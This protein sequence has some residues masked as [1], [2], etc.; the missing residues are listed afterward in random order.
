MVLIK[1]L[2]LSLSLFAKTELKELTAK[3]NIQN[4]RYLTSKND[5]TFYVK[6][7]KSLSVSSNLK[8][9]EIISNDEISDYSIIKHPQSDLYLIT[10]FKN[11]FSNLTANPIGQIYLF[12]IQT[13]SL[14]PFTKG[15]APSFSQNGEYFYYYNP[16]DKTIYFYKLINMTEPLKIKI[17]SN[18]KNFTPNFVIFDLKNIFFTDIN[19]NGEQGII[20]LDYEQQKRSTYL[21]AND[22]KTR[23]EITQDDQ[24]LYFLETN[25]SS[26]GFTYIYST[27]KD[28]K[29]LSKRN[30]LF[31]SKT[32]N[33]IE[34]RYFDEKLYFIKYHDSIYSELSYFDL[35][36]KKAFYI[37]DLDFVSSY[38]SYEKNIYVPYREKIY[39]VTD[40][41]NNFVMKKEIVEK[42][43]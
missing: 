9:Y 19:N 18:F 39:S 17:N 40:N 5:T 8:A 29:D 13:K 4:I 21:K 11:I 20:H 30:I 32:G 1:T 42:S 28:E 33:A 22:R 23:Y 12:D 25:Y 34:L 3:Q 10:E 15:I 2:L 43:E 35:K 31:E 24:N 26:E 7:T 16:T 38:Y 14:T 27:P 37:T 6:G 36:E 41:A